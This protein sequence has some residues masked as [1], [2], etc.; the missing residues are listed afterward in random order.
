VERREW[1]KW[2]A[3]D[4]RIVVRTEGRPVERYAIRLE[5]WDGTAWQTVH[6]FDNAHGQHDSHRYRR[7][8][9]LAAEPLPART[10]P[11]AIPLAVRLLSAEWE[12][13]MERWKQ[14]R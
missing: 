11:E 14:D 9:K 3:A 10:V 1:V 7:D 4:A 13:I 6:L 2:L 8:Q 12:S 5:G